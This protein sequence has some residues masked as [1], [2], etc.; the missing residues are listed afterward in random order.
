MDSIAIKLSI[1]DLNSSKIAPKCWSTSNKRKD[2]LK[3]KLSLSAQS[4]NQFRFS[5]NLNEG[6]T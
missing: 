2:F 3:I 5:R 1:N 4:I 6:Y